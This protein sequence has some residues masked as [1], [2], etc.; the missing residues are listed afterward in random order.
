M[1]SGV[2]LITASNLVIKLFKDLR[3][4]GC[5]NPS[6]LLSARGSLNNLYPFNGAKEAE[7]TE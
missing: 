1:K 7:S 6:A 3:A 5:G 4:L 2:N